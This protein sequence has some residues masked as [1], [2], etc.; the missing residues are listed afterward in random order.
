MNNHVAKKRHILWHTGDSGYISAASLPSLAIVGGTLSARA[1]GG[2]VT[3]AMVPAPRPA[4][5]LTYHP[6]VSALHVLLLWGH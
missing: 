4:S 3:R 6:I 5:T 2:R 1:A